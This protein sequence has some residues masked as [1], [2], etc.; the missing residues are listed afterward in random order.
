[1]SERHMHIYTSGD[2][3]VLEISI[4]SV[5]HN[6]CGKALLLGQVFLRPHGPLEISIHNG[7]T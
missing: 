6:L 4:D 2:H 1:M 5:Y 7:E 3:F